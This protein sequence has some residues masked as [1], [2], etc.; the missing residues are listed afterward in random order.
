[1]KN[2]LNKSIILFF[3]VFYVIPFHCFSQKNRNTKNEYLNQTFPADTAVIFAPNIISNG[4]I[5]RDVAISPDGNEMY[6]GVASRSFAYICYSKKVN[7]KWSEPE[8]AP[9]SGN[10]QYFDFEPH[11]TPDGKHFYFLSTRPQ[12]GQEPK[13]GWAYQDIWAMD[14]TTDGW[15]EPYNLGEPINTSDPEFYPSV[16][17][18][19]TMYFTREINKTN[20]IYRSKFIDNKFQAAERVNIPVDSINMF[21]AFISPDESFLIFCTSDL[22]DKIG[23]TD[24]YIS[25]RST[26]DKWSKP[27]NMSAKLNSKGDNASSAYVTADGKYLFFASNRSK[28]TAGKAIYKNLV[29]LGCKPQNGSSDIYWIGTQLIEELRKK[30]W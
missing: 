29:E 18:T 9:F 27:L 2:Y 4:L 1:M 12:N 5:N 17:K 25:F 15:S 24:Y 23:N 11:I 22:K 28:P 30:A 21:N 19:G 26:D 16:T 10:S 7:N 20:F 8:I 14:K 3:V 13:A 6:F